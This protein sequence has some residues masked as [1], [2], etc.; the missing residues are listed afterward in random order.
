[1]CRSNIYI[2]MRKEP[3]APEGF[4]YRWDYKKEEWRLEPSHDQLS[5]YYE[6]IRGLPD[7]TISPMDKLANLKNEITANPHE[8]I[9]PP[10][11]IPP[12]TNSF[13]FREIY[14][15][16]RRRPP[17][18]SSYLTDLQMEREAR[19]HELHFHVSDNDEAF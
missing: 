14:D 7:L 9:I 1:M 5:A 17:T 16:Y 13:P 2:R 11:P 18:G 4:E 12:R 6:Y 3:V 19:E 10:D 15:P 8:W